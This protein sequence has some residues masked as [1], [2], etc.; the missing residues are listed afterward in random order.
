MQEEKYYCRTLSEV[1]GE[2]PPSGVI[3]PVMDT[4][5]EISGIVSTTR[6]TTVTEECAFRKYYLCR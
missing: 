3:P 5:E 6:R 1:I 4:L 2:E